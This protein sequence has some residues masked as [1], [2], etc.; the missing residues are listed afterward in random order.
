MVQ[1]GNVTKYKIEGVEKDTEYSV[2]VRVVVLSSTEPRLTFEY[3]V[4]G[5]GV[6]S[7]PTGKLNTCI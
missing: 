4:W 5:G 2:Q 3:G 1:V 7:E 6:I